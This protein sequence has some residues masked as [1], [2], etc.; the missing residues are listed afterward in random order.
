MAVPVKAAKPEFAR[1]LLGRLA[2]LWGTSWLSSAQVEFDSR[3]RASL[4][5]SNGPKRSIRLHVGLK[6][7]AG[8]LAEVLC[9]E[10]AHLV[11][12]EDTKGLG[13]KHGAEWRA[14]M[15]QA[16]YRP[17]VRL[18]PLPGTR[19]PR[20]RTVARFEHACP[21][22]HFR[23]FAARKMVGWRCATCVSDGLDGTLQI[24]QVEARGQRGS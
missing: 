6:R 17:R 20:K 4:G 11:V 9:H 19:S 1:R 22:C 7:R 16:G 5:R 14:L 18:P 24:T 3:L 15:L 13:R 8:L 2:S 12:Y 23:R 21:V 10:A